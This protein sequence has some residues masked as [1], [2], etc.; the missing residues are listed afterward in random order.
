MGVDGGLRGEG[1][2]YLR[3]SSLR[4]CTDIEWEDLARWLSMMTFTILLI[5]L[6]YQQQATANDD[7][8][9]QMFFL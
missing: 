3:V 6:P 5:T 7:P 9:P 4:V 8:L 1:V 2:T